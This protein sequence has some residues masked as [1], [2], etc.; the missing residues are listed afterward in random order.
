[1]T[2]GAI[3][4]QGKEPMTSGHAKTAVSGL[5]CPAP[6]EL[7]RLRIG[8]IAKRFVFFVMEIDSMKS[9]YSIVLMLCAA[10][11]L[12][13][14]VADAATQASAFP[15]QSPAA[16]P[17]RIPDVA[18]RW[19]EKIPLRDGI[20]LNA[21][22]Y[23]SRDL[24]TPAP[25]VFTL[26]PYVGQSYHDRGL[27]FAANGYTFLTVDVRGRG[28]SEGTFVPLLQEA[29]DGHDIVEWLARQPFCNGKISLWGGSY[30]GY[31]QWATAKEFPPH[32]SSIIPVASPFAGVDFPMSNNIPYPY[33]MQWLTLTSGR[34][35]QD[36]IFGDAPFWESIYR[37]L[38]LEHRPFRALDQIAGNPS[39][40]F[41]TWV[42]HPMQD[43]YWDAYNPSAEQYAKIDMP[44]LSITGHYDGDQPGALEHYRQHMAN[45]SA[46]AR[47][48][49]WLIIGPWDHAG[50][51]TPLPEFGGLK[52]GPASLVD[53]NALHKAWYDWTLK[54]AAK[55]DYLKAAV[56]YYMTG[57]ETWRYAD[58]LDAVTAQMRPLQLNSTAGRAN[59]V[60][61]S[62]SLSSAA[63]AQGFDQYVYDPLDITASELSADTSVEG[64][65]D[66]RGVFANG[67][68]SLIYHT[69]PFTGDTDL[70]G[71]FVF[72]AYLDIDQ[73]D[74]DFNA[75]IYDIAPDGSSVFLAADSKR[76]RH[77]ESLRAQ[78]LVTPGTI[79]R[80][81]FDSFTF[82]ARTLAK[83]HRLRL[84][85]GPI[86]H[87]G[88]Q[89]NYN[90]GG[91]VADE[92]EKDA[93]TVTVKL[94]HDREHP[95]ALLM[96]IAAASK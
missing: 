29:K 42:D 62:G 38:Y 26:T 1:M 20:K 76:A 51:R 79:L 3:F 9:I 74:T 64:L 89:K 41:Q 53:M 85:F 54:G 33:D 36:K 82:I 83:G 58:S 40:I 39:T 68:K 66:Q 90:A 71:H 59:D 28:N 37:K 63:D 95:S 91:V 72:D 44:I 15:L 86:N 18:I 77:R 81:R 80:Y 4:T 48:Q 12:D 25:C 88:A 22:I 94:H 21:T 34:T 45:A 30:A 73:P 13:L 17:A 61:A 78:K 27:Y 10:Y 75:A 5:A 52:F 23:R 69:E 47:A 7:R 6:D 87:P 8:I 2:G 49:H 43:A 16:S 92:T 57:S 55:P 11:T 70:A 19:G 84:V 67:G 14:A 32:L 35:A 56:A 93:R 60:F 31:D 50:T 46:R 24:K 96:P 65:T